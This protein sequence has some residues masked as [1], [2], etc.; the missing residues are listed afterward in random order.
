MESSML[1]THFMRRIFST[2]FSV[3]LIALSGCSL[4]S[5]PSLITD[6][7]FKD[8]Q[9]EHCVQQN[10]QQELA[11]ITQLTCNSQGIRS[12][13]E[14]RM[15]PS[16]TDLILLDNALTEI[17]V[18]ELPEL[19]RLI[20]AGNQLTDI[21]LLANKK[22]TTLN[23]SGN[24]FT[25][26]DLSQN[27]KLNSVYAYKMPIT[28]LD[29]SNLANL[30]DLGLSQHKLNQVDLTNNPKL[31][32]LNLSLGPLKHIDL[33]ATPALTHLYL[34]GNQLSELDV[35]TNPEIMVMSVRNNQLTELSL[36]NGLQLN[37]LKADYNQLIDLDLSDNINLTN[38]ELNNNRLTSL[39][40][41]SQVELTTL[42]AFNNPLQSLI[43]P[44]N[45]KIQLLSVE[46]TPYALT[47]SNKLS[48]EQSISQQLSPRVSVI[49]AGLI[50]QKG[51]QYDVFPTQLVT[52][53]I[54]Q[55]IGFRYQVS[56]PKTAVNEVASK[57]LNQQ[58]F[59]I[60]LRMTHP[61]IIDPKTDKGFKVSSWTDTMFKH[62]RN[63]AMW[64]FGEA[65]EM[66]TGRW[67]LEVIYRDAVLAK[68]SFMLVNM[69]EEAET[70]RKKN[71][72][73]D[74]TITLEKLVKE[75]ESIICAQEKY[76]SCLG[77][78]SAN[79]CEIS[80]KPFRPQCQQ[81]AFKHLSDLGINQE[82]S[83]DN[84]RR[85]FSHYTACMGANYIQTT[86]LKAQEVGRC[87]AK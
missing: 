55:Y 53:S 52:P 35:D 17:D 87:L 82:D 58:Q 73:V 76:R 79:L 15:M 67:T 47:T 24:R 83:A 60:T 77:F 31:R 75:G 45:N 22:L 71:Q 36:S 64:Y 57:H 12:V 59:P 65:Y 48:I 61:E 51:N 54:G 68:K 39:D 9:F 5:S 6:I 13:D 69:D 10:G 44:V 80:I 30:A 70:Q 78:S 21:D 66:V 18:S 29:V 33:S 19:K 72:G 41:T 14:I 63:L 84:L 42:T 16:L 27:P 2:S 86:A 28:K 38:L 56:L 8:A 37:E 25:Q 43:L 62:D 74:N 32:L 49:E 81:S 23:I 85:F 50:S 7:E 46:G 34:A 11:Q 3:S 26:F 1:T 20:V 4:I 40:L